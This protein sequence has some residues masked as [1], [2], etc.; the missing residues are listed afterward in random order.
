MC[1]K[2]SVLIF[3]NNRHGSRKVQDMWRL[4]LPPSVRGQIW[5]L[6]IGN[7]L[8]ITKG[9]TSTSP[10]SPPCFSLIPLLP[11]SSSTYLT[12]VQSCLISVMDTL[13]R[14]RWLCLGMHPIL[15]KTKKKI[16]RRRK[17]KNK[18]VPS[19]SINRSPKS[20]MV[21]AADGATPSKTKRGAE[22]VPVQMD[23]LLGKEGTVALVSILDLPL[24][25]PTRELFVPGIYYSIFSFLL[26]F[27]F[28]FLSFFSFFVY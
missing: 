15:A 23:E 11:L 6:A 9:I 26:Y 28:S 7:E 12:I 20:K 21:H 22:F 13:S 25:F 4:G 19:D 18:R 27:S 1:Y 24:D 3:K 5:K 14:P 10:S 16:E 8:M 2:Y 17:G